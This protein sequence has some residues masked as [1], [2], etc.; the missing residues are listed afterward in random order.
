MTSTT[1]TAYKV[2]KVH[3][4]VRVEQDVVGLDVAVDDVL[5]VDVAESAAQLGDPEANR[6]LG[7]GFS[8]DVEA[9]VTARHQV[10]D[11]VEVFDVLETV[12]Q[13]AQEGVVE[14]LEHPS[15]SNHVPYA[16]AAHHYTTSACVE[17]TTGP[18]HF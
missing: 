2:S 14:V 1:G 13:I 12:A 7:K 5:F 16:L 8:R 3:V 17:P 6:V 15:F 4:A 11:N 9:E 10:D 18:G